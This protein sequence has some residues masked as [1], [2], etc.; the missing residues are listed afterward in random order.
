MLTFII[1]LKPFKHHL[2]E[3]VHRLCLEVVFD[4]I[5][6]SLINTKYP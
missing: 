2:E 4:F 1:G 5:I 3:V 6:E